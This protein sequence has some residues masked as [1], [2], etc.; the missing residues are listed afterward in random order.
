MHD[1][2]LS[3]VLKSAYVMKLVVCVFKIA[4]HAK[5]CRFLRSVVF[6]KD[7]KFC[8][9]VPLHRDNGHIINYFKAVLSFLAHCLL[10]TDRNTHFTSWEPQ[11]MALFAETSSL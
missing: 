2:S 7:L 10:Q 9:F 11:Y 4:E 8:P 1:T 3:C 6:E 5:Y